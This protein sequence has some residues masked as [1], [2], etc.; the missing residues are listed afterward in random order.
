MS[1]NKAA[2][3]NARLAALRSTP[4]NGKVY[5]ADDVDY[6]LALAE[7]AGGGLGAISPQWIRSQAKLVAGTLNELALWQRFASYCR[8]CAQSG[9]SNPMDFEEFAKMPAN[10]AFPRPIS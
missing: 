1:E 7:T 10:Q 9:E 2:E 8:C 5:Q 6:L 4:H 3:V